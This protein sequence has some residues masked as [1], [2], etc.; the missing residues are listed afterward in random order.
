MKITDI[1]NNDLISLELSGNTKQAIISEMIG[2]LKSQGLLN[3]E[4]EFEQAIYAREEESST[5]IGMGIAI[6]HAKT[7]AVKTPS[8][9]FGLKKQAVNWESIDDEPA[10]LFFMIAVPKASASNDHLVILTQ[11]SRK[12]IDDEFR[13][14]LMKASSKEEVL[15]LL[16]TL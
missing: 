5:G 7:D 13:E 8:L 3:D 6:P 9:V 4:A 12:L 10:N 11:L 1:I 16:G 14:K 15:E 2:M